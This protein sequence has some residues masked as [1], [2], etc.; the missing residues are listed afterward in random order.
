LFSPAAGAQVPFCQ[1]LSPLPALAEYVR[2]Y[3][4]YG[5]FAE[6]SI[7]HP[8][9][10]SV[11]PLLTFYLGER[12]PAFEYAAGRTRLLPGV[13]AVGPCDHRVA[14][15]VP[16]GRMTNFTVLFRHARD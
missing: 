6:D 4:Y 13:I 14:D 3:Q 11:F 16:T 5:C 15:L 2:G 10:V 1:R 8:F 12:C 9:A 7:A